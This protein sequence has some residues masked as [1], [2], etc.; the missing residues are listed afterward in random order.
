MTLSAKPA[1][2]HKDATLTS[3]TTRSGGAG[4][5]AACIRS[6]LNSAG[7]Y[8]NLACLNFRV[9][10][11]N[12]EE[13]RAKVA[14]VLQE[15]IRGASGWSGRNSEA[16]NEAEVLVQAHNHLRQKELVFVLDLRCYVELAKAAGH[17]GNVAQPTLL[18]MRDPD[19]A[20]RSQNTY[21]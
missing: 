11:T 16:H 18:C 14:K 9:H 10:V 19:I 20:Y 12:T 17:V 13:R 7:L 6:R 3:L 2:L 21:M 4:K 15:G 5:E 8:P 1:M